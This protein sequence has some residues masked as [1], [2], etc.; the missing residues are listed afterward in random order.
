MVTNF[1]KIILVCLIPHHHFSPIIYPRNRYK[2]VYPVNIT[3]TILHVAFLI[4]L[5]AGF[6]SKLARPLHGPLLAQTLCNILP[7]LHF[8][9]PTFI[10]LLMFLL[11]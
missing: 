9:I 10:Y 4:M 6:Y 5:T 7:L 2:L 1:H 11:I 3:T 8:P